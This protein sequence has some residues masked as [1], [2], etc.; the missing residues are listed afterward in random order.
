VPAV[1]EELGRRTG[2]PV[3]DPLLQGA[4]PLAAIV[5]AL[6]PAARLAAG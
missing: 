1:C 6:L 3:L 5:A 4:G 2:L